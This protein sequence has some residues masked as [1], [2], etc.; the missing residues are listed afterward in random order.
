[1]TF[2]ERSSRLRPAADR[3]WRAALTSTGSRS[4]R[5]YL[6]ARLLSGS[7]RF[8]LAT[9]VPRTARKPCPKAEAICGCNLAP[10]STNNR[11]MRHKGR[12]TS[13]EI[14]AMRTRMLDGIK[15]I[16]FGTVMRFAKNSQS[17]RCADRSIFPAET[18]HHP[19]GHS[20]RTSIAVVALFGLA[21][22]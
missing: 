13:V 12:D 20:E 8:D 21:I 5:A 15:Q 22:L 14:T 10:Q 16:L 19:A 7:R 18:E 17:W 6:L 2:D 4:R 11:E 1:M 9:K 3:L